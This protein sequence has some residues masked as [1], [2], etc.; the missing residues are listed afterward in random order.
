MVIR[1]QLHA[2][3]CAAATRGESN[4]AIIRARSNLSHTAS[5]VCCSHIGFRFRKTSACVEIQE[6][7]GAFTDEITLL[8]YLI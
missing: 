2:C 4:T 8:Q 1:I 7:R 5:D 6:D 3:R